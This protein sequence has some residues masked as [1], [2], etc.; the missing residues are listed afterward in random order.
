MQYLLA[1]FV[2]FQS[3]T[4]FAFERVIIWGHKLHSHTHSYVHYGFHKAFKHLGYEVHWLDNDDDISEINFANSLFITEHQ[5]DQN[6]PLR[7]DSYYV[8]HNSSNSKFDFIKQLNHYISIRTYHDINLKSDTLQEVEPYIYYDIPKSTLVC[9]WA[10]DLLPSEIEEQKKLLL[11]PQ[12]RNHFEIYWVGTIGDGEGGNIHQISPFIEA[13]KKNHVKF[14]HSSPWGNPISFDENR[15]LIQKSYMAPT[16]CGAWQVKNGYI[17]CRIFK[18][19]SYGKIGVTNSQR[20]YELFQ[21]KIVYNEDTHQLFYD[22]KKALKNFDQS[23]MLELMDF[24]KEHHTYLNRCA[25]IISFIKLL[26]AQGKI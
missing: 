16:I 1:L 22:A 2:L 12:K 4:L 19:I 24:V 11:N 7:D 26:S 21:K 25:H 10:T 23:Q 9:P 20:V 15:K 17:P 6:M 14:I 13:C 18:N 8:V 3:L 5:V